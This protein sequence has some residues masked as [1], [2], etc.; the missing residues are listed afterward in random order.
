MMRAQLP[1]SSDS[2]T[3][4]AGTLEVR[5][6]GAQGVLTAFPIKGGE[7]RPLLELPSGVYHTLQAGGTR[8]VFV[9]GDPRAELWVLE[10]VE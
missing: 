1:W 7:P 10:G 2:E 3:V 5:D 8:L 9:S 6:P 4:F